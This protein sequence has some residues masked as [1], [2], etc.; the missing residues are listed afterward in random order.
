MSR[1]SFF[2]SGSLSLCSDN[3]SCRWGKTKSSYWIAYTN[4]KTNKRTQPRGRKLPLLSSSALAL[5]GLLLCGRTEKLLEEKEVGETSE[6]ARGRSPPP[7]SCCVTR[8][9]LHSF[10]Y[11]RT[12]Y[13][14]SRLTPSRP[15]DKKQ[16]EQR[17]RRE[18]RAIS[19][20]YCSATRPSA[21]PVSLCDSCATSS[22]SSRNPRSE[23]CL[24]V[25]VSEV[26][27]AVALCCHDVKCSE[28]GWTVWVC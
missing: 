7:P 8:R 26:G 12:P 6:R 10:I 11:R 22:L 21:S 20:S 24:C 9:G 14:R 17:C 16:Q 25:P 5:V 19:S 13:T 18:R 4:T 23:V 1:L 28:C 15:P 2:P 27:T 3:H